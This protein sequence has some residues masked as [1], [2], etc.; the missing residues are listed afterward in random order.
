[1]GNLASEVESRLGACHICGKIKVLTN[2]KCKE[3]AIDQHSQFKRDLGFI[4]EQLELTLIEKNK[5]Y[6]DSAL[7]PCRIFSR[8][9]V[10][11]QINV[12]IDDK[13]NRIINSGEYPGD[14]DELDLLG[15]L[16]LRRIGRSRQ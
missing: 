15:Y 16:I 14:D 7:N 2:R 9:D 8:A 6:G 4:L 12:R 1:M 3:C 5:A 11:E 10:L 13:L